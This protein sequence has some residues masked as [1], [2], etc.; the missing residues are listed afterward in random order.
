VGQNTTYWTALLGCCEASGHVL[1]PPA[2]SGTARWRNLG[3][4]AA[5]WCRERGFWMRRRSR[6]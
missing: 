6:G 1:L 3:A 2:P 5:A 4:P